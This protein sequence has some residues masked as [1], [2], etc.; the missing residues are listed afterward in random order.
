MTTI[1]V[2]TVTDAAGTG[3]P[4]IP[5]GVTIAG[6]ALASINSMD[7]TSSASE[8]ASPKN[9]AV[10][11]N[12]GNDK[13]SQYMNDAWVEVE[14]TTYVPPTNY[15]S[16]AIG[17]GGDTGTASS[18][19]RYA[20]IATDTSVSTFGN[21]TVARYIAG[22]VSDGTYGVCAGGNYSNPIDYITIATTGNATDFG[23]LSGNAAP[24]G[25]AG[26]L[27]YGIVPF[28]SNNITY[29]NIDRITIATPGNASDFGDLTAF[30]SQ[31]RMA[32]AGDTSSRVAIAGGG[33]GTYSNI[34]TIQYVT[35]T[36]PGNTTTGASLSSARSQ[37]SGCVDSVGNAY[38]SGG[39]EGFSGYTG[40]IDKINLASL[41][42]ATN[43][44]NTGFGSN[45]SSSSDGTYNMLMGGWS[46]NRYSC[47]LRSN[48]ATGGTASNIGTI[49][50]QTQYIAG[51]SGD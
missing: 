18:I 51:C 11:W 16:R 27:T 6:T 14:Y 1:K 49:T 17:F 19:I 46:G 12:T 28:V 40:T 31:G 3:S 47:L 43:F 15:G 29:G 22:A 21:L 38:Y 23:D 25:A 30:P 44:G 37:M 8:P 13:F 36:A 7:Y 5:D 33:T 35:T 20:V 9:G 10:W 50:T 42:T 41:G 39:Q 48:L 2:D 45:S 26:D 32:S 4:N 24:N 34:S